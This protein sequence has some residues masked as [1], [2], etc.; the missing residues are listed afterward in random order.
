MTWTNA[1]LILVM[2][3]LSVLRMTGFTSQAYQAAA[4]LYV[5]GLIGAWLVSRKW[6]YVILAVVIS[7]V[8]VAAFFIL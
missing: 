2:L 4:H 6:R 7:G 8:E 3:S 5:G 1:L